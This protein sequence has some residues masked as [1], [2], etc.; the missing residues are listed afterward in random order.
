VHITNPG[1]T[2]WAS[3]AIA[4]EAGLLLGAAYKW[5]GTLWLPIGIHWAWNFAQGNIF[6]FAVSGN[7]AGDSIIVS[8]VDGPAWLTGGAF[9]A[10]ASVIAVVVGALASAW[11][12]WQVS[13]RNH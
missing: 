13:R 5:S 11:F 9:G 10:E 3:I 12:I 7:Q 2:L 8:Q 4:I 6:G 1:G